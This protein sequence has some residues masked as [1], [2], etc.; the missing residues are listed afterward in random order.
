MWYDLIFDRYGFEL[1]LSCYHSLLDDVSLSD[2][3]VAEV[4]LL[5]GLVGHIYS[6]ALILGELAYMLLCC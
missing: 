1:C 4:G 2:I 3:F 6:Q 5:F